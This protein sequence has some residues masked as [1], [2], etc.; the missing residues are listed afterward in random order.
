MRFP[1]GEVWD[2]IV[3]SKSIM[4]SVVVLKSDI[5]AEKS[6]DQL[7]RDFPGRS[8]F[9]FC[10]SIE[11]RPEVSCTRRTD[12]IDPIRSFLFFDHAERPR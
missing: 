8:I 2:Y 11:G 12:A 6:K 10:N 4:T 9:D 1:R 5:A 7:W 3:L